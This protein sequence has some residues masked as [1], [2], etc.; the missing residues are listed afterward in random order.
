MSASFWKAPLRTADLS[1]MAILAVALVGVVIG[2]Q[3]LSPHFLSLKN[4]LNSTRFMAEIGLLSLGMA[5]V[6]I[7]GG[8]DL[9]VGSLLALCCIIAGLC[10]SAG[11]PE[12]C[13]VVV[14]L[15]AG[16]ALGSINGVLVTLAKLPPIIVTLATLAIF[17]GLALGVS[18][19]AAYQMD[20]GFGRLG[21]GEIF[22]LPTQLLILLAV[23]T[24][25]IFTMRVTRFGRMLYATGANLEVA[26]FSG[27]PTGRVLLTTYILSGLFAAMAALIFVSRVS[28]A[29]A[30]AG[31][32]Y[33]LDAITIV[34]LA[35]IPLSGGRGQILSVLLALVTVGLIR[36]GM[37]LAFIQSDLQSIIIGAL[38]L[39]AVAINR[40]FGLATKFFRKAR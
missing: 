39:G 13:I 31:V 16:L 9:S 40:L 3:E 10:G 6:V 37:A 30:N 5:L 32:G 36:N 24:I 35:G 2:M 23:S 1:Q 25:L 12:W 28:S 26:R 20:E 34:V 19:G 18:G 8:I 38:L 29:K 4:L 7:G 22:G 15:F 11:L 27:I 14:T 21:R 17:R 33:E